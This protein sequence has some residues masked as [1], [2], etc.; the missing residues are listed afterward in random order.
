AYWLSNTGSFISS[1]FYGTTLPAWVNEFNAEK[2]YLD[3]IKKGWQMSMPLSTYN[4]SQADR[5]PYEGKVHGQDAVFPYD[6]KAMY[7]KDGAGIIR[8][9]PYGNDILTEFAKRTIDKEQ[10]GADYDTDFLAVSF[11]TPDY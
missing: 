2:K 10:M 11:S 5:N 6:L 8:T 7:E 3:Y 4:E 1:T 9:T